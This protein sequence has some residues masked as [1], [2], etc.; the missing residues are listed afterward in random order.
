MLKKILQYLFYGIFWGCTCFVLTGLIGYEIAGKAWL[1]PIM[2]D[3]TRHAVGGMLT[4]I[5]CASSTIVYT[6]KRLP[7]WA[8]ILIHFSVGLG[9]YFSIAFRLGWMP[10]QTGWPLAAF[11]L[12]GVSVFA[13][14][15]AGCY[16]YNRYEARKFNRRLREL[17]KEVGD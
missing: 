3:F 17:E 12:I 2:A 16:F 6:V 13:C 7:L 1:E 10:V 15:W 14:I 11:I 4:G 8:A 5:F 9:G